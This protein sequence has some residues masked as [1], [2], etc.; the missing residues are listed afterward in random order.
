MLNFYMNDDENRHVCE[1]QLI[2]F[3]MLSQRT[4]QEGHGA[5]NVFRAASELLQHKDLTQHSSGQKNPRS[6]TSFKK[7]ISQRSRRTIVVV[8]HEG[9]VKHDVSSVTAEGLENGNL[10][11]NSSGQK[12]HQS[13]PTTNSRKKGRNPKVFPEM[14]MPPTNDEP[15]PNHVQD[16]RD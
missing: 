1:V 8:P 15:R 9:D 5:Y 2:H 6:L 4:T 11:Q 12:K 10:T 14:T 7:V 13:R 16:V 3:K